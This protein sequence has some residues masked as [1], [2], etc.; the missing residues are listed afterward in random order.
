MDHCRVLLARGLLQLCLL[1]AA[2]TGV[3]V[4]GVSH[5]VA[6]G[7]PCPLILVGARSCLDVG[8]N[9]GS[10]LEPL[11]TCGLHTNVNGDAEDAEVASMG[12]TS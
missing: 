4:C 9:P 10:P 12:E 11:L 3:L 8:C 7:H 5:R 1:V 6:F 2:V